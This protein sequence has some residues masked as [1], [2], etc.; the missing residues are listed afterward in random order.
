MI[1]MVSEIRSMLH[2][3]PLIFPVHA[4]TLTVTL[5]LRAF[6]FTFI[7]FIAAGDCSVCIKGLKVLWNQ[8]SQQQPATTK[9]QEFMDKPG[10]SLLIL[11]NSDACF[12]FS[13]ICIMNETQMLIAVAFSLTDFVWLFL[14]SFLYFQSYTCISWR[15]LL[16]EVLELDKVFFSEFASREKLLRQLVL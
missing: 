9:R 13:E 8:C 16:N 1:I 3:Q 6:L 2:S 12:S 10:S 4:G 11:I 15:H 7:Y 5:L 14:F